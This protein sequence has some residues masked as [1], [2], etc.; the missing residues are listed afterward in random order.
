MIN[1]EI[2]NTIENQEKEAE[3]I[4]T[5]ES[6]NIFGE[7]P[8]DSDLP[9]NNPNN[10][11]NDSKYFKNMFQKLEDAEYLCNNVERR[12]KLKNNLEQIKI[13]DLT[14]KELEKLSADQEL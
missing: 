9:L 11:T 14:L 6:E 8:I 10:L 1:E 3:E 13:N 7:D 4:L 12:Q 2:K 5:Q